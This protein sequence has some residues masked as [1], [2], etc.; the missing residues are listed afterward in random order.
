ME[1]FINLLIFNENCTNSLKNSIFFTNYQFLIYFIRSIKFFLL[2]T[3]FLFQIS[4]QI[5]SC[6]STDDIFGIEELTIYKGEHSEK[7]Y[8]CA[9]DMLDGYFYDLLMNLLSEKGVTDE[10]VQKVSELATQYEQTLFVN[11][12]KDAKQFFESK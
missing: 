3:H 7:V 10:F 9:G 2:Q 12:L 11:L 6:L 5:F 8:A 4:N 1:H